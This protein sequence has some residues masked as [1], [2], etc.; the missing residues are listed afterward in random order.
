MANP[1]LALAFIAAISLSCASGIGTGVLMSSPSADTATVAE[2]PTRSDAP[3]RAPVKAKAT[4]APAAPTI[5]DG[6]WTVGVD[7]PAGSYRTT[8]NVGTRCYWSITKT[9]SNGSDIVDNDLPPGG[10]PSVT[11]KKGQDFKTDNCGKWRKV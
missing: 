3:A 9:G 6:M 10:R 11:L 7:F 8:A 5:T 4:P 1:R 2:Q